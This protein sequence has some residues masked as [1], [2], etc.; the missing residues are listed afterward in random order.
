MPA[1]NPLSLRA[2]VLFGALLAPSVS[3]ASADTLDAFATEHGPAPA[4]APAAASPRKIEFT[5]EGR[6]GFYVHPSAY[7]SG[8]S[9]AAQALYQAQLFGPFSLLVSGLGPGA[10][11]F[12]L[13]NAELGASSPDH[14]EFDVLANDRVVLSRVNL[15]RRFGFSRRADL[16]FVADADDEGR[17]RV[18]LRTI[19]GKN[20]PRL[21]FLAVEDALGRPL[22]RFA[23]LDHEPPGFREQAS[24]AL[25]GVTLDLE[26]REPRWK[27]QYKLRAGDPRLTAAD[28]VGPDALVYPDFRRA[29]R[30][31]GIPDLPVAADLGEL[32][33]RPGADIADLLEETAARVA[34]AGGGAVL[35][36]E[37]EF[38]LDR[39]VVVRGSGVVLRGAG[40]ERT[41]LLFRYA[42]L[43][44][45]VVFAF[46]RPGA[47][48]AADTH[49]EAHADPR[50]LK[51]I[52]LLVGDQEL[53]RT[54]DAAS[55]EGPFFDVRVSGDK[56]LAALPADARRARVV[57]RATYADG[58]V[59]EAVLDTPV[60]RSP[61]PRP[62]ALPTYLGPGA[63]TFL[64]GPAGARDIRL[65]ADGR[66]GD[67]HLTLPVGHGLGVGDRVQ[68]EAPATPEWNRLTRNECP[69][70]P[71]RAAR[72]E[73]TAVDGET[74]RFAEAL[75]LDFPA[76]DRSHVRRIA[77]LADVGVEDFTLQQTRDLWTNGILFQNVWGAWARRVDVLKAGRH[78]LYM[79]QAKHCVIADARLD[80]AWFQGGG[81]TAYAGWDA[82]WD[83]LMERVET[84]NLRHAPNL[85]WGAA[86]NVIRDSRFFGSD[87]QWHAGWAHENLLEN[88]FVDSRRAGGPS[89]GYPYGLW[90][91]PPEDR[92]HGPIGP[93]NVIYGSDF[94]SHGGGL[95]LGGSNEGWLIL[96]NRFDVSKGA[97]LVLRTA[98]FDHV[99]ENNTF[100]LRA[101]RTPPVWFATPDCTGVELIGNRFYAPS[102]PADAHGGLAAPAVDRDNLLAALP[103]DPAAFP[104]RPVPPAPSLLDWQRQNHPLP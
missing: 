68:L 12:I 64:A 2:L 19:P 67:R 34:A 70:G 65:T 28:L 79:V 13:G 5:L 35:I 25:T 61:R 98:S 40:R 22:G 100:V 38:F 93:R 53:A 60:D 55:A 26:A 18:E 15:T 46:P 48:L 44:A 92:N 37:G 6:P 91:T 101:P 82:A 29:G 33:A 23:A 4:S 11:R 45:G 102:A 96:H 54:R 104:P 97:A 24:L 95:W 32:G 51:S 16:A 57:A 86:G 36:P 69:W 75:R 10:H 17:V 39:P 78:P 41:R 71:W 62:A 72:L 49:V 94:I 74:I 85:Q 87:T 103:A 31:G 83:C 76:A 1:Q 50:G 99:V 66:R 9:E 20:L 89:G 90:A 52:V 56:I 3:G 43:D 21:S 73:I 30:P 58:R 81:G 77:P 84:R 59:R 7:V 80:D 63:I 42:A 27:G 47:A 8:A 88:V 14:R